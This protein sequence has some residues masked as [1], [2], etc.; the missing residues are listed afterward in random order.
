MDRQLQITEVKNYFKEHQK[1]LE[2]QARK[3]A[4]AKNDDD[5]SGP[6]FLFN[7]STPP[8]RSEILSSLPPRLAAD[9]LVSRYFCSN[10]PA[11]RELI[12]FTTAPNRHR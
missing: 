9:R 8:D 11:L 12:L 6:G 5:S 10:D 4:D 1:Q 3:V 7:V 2:E